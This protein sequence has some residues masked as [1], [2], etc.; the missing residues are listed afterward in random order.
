MYF[1]VGKRCNKDDFLLKKSLFNLE[2]KKLNNKKM[3]T[4]I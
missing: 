3:M 2:T 1:Y 4:I